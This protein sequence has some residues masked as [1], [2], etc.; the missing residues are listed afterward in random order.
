MFFNGILLLYRLL[1]LYQQHVSEGRTV[2]EVMSHV[3]LQPA[4]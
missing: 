1:G 4:D 3:A 2:K